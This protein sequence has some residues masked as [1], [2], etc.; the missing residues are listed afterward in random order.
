MPLLDQHNILT[1]VAGHNKD[2][3]KLL[4][5]LTIDDAD[6]AWFLDAFEETIEDLHRFLGPL[7]VTARHLSQSALRSLSRT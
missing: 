2:V 7:R 1:Q 4:P 3:I 6:V 5:P